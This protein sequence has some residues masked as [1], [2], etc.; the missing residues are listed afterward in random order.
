V[1]VDDLEAELSGKELLIDP[2][3]P[4]ELIRVAFIVDNWAAEG[5]NRRLFGCR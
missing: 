4:S 1:V 3:G 5:R 2:T